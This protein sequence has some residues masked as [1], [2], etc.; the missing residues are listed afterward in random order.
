M[1]AAMSADISALNAD[2]ALAFGPGAVVAHRWLQTSDRALVADAVADG[3]PVVVKQFLGPDRSAVIE[4][5]RAEH[6]AIGPHLAKGRFRLAVWQRLS[7]PHGVAVL[8][9]APGQRLD[10]LLAQAGAPERAVILGLVGGWLSAFTAPRRHLA[11]MNLHAAIRR[12]KEAANPDLPPADRD[13]TGAA[14]SRMRAMARD[15]AGQDLVQSGIHADFTPYNLTLT[16]TPGGLELWGFDLQTTRKRPVALDAASFLVIAGLRLA[17]VGA[18]PLTGGLPQPDR[19]ALLATCPDA[20]GAVLE[21]FLGDR[22]LRA[23]HDAARPAHT[24]AARTALQ[25][26]LG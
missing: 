8:A 23:L 9:R 26:W 13:L 11:P 24:A 6:D 3:V 2:L 18:V 16:S 25:G 20:G 12:R 14:L 7:A 15:L 10:A 17:P 22:L 21:F 4:T 1:I 19:A 5:L